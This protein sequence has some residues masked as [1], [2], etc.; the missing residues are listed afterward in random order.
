MIIVKIIISYLIKQLTD[1]LYLSQ[2]WYDPTVV[3]IQFFHGL[4]DPEKLLVVPVLRATVIQNLKN[5]VTGTYN[6][7][8]FTHDSLEN[9][10]FYTESVVL[11]F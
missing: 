3:F 1:F 9:S 8:I 2:G 4:V 10:K 11:G 5:K 6:R 7:N